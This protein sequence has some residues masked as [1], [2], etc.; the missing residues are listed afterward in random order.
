MEGVLEAA[1]LHKDL[2]SL[3]YL[4]DGGGSVDVFGVIVGLRVSLVFRP[5]NGL[6]GAY[7]P[8]AKPGILVTTE[9]PLSIQ[10][11]TGA[12]ELGHF[13]MQH[14]GSL[15]DTTVIQRSP[16]A[17]DYEPMEVAANSFATAFLMPNWL[18]E[19]HAE[20]QKWTRLSFSD[21]HTVYQLSLRIGASYQATCW[22][23]HQQ[24]VLE[25][26]QAKILADAEPKG[27]KQELLG[28]HGLKSWY[29]NIWILTEKDQDILIHGEPHDIFIVRL[30]EQSGAGYLWNLDQVKSAG[31]NIV[32]DERV[33]PPHDVE[34]GGAIER[35]LTAKSEVPTTGSFEF[36]QRRPWD[37]SD[38]IGRL[39][40]GYD[41][42]GKEQG[43]PRVAREKLSVA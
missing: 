41:L 18:L 26:K 36:L 42:R 25:L 43:K 30:R 3:R 16:F 6:L 1:R 32:S 28:K 17:K 5:L 7:L 12:H 23:L 27:L 37:E 8:G 9:R 40:L 11:L 34:I 39:S 29:P 38:V 13:F 31:F 4:R 15:D 24:G 22:G 2:D 14:R 35:V 21:P 33:V 10:R 20:R 19:H